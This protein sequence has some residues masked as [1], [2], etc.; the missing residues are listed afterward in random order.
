MILA[1]LQVEKGEIRPAVDTL[2][3]TLPYAA[4]RPII[5]PSSPHCYSAKDATRKR[6]A[7]RDGTAQVA[8][9]RSVVDGLG[10]SLQADNRLPEARNAFAGPRHPIPCLPS[11]WPM[12]NSN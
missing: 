2:R 1:R 8:A 12:S 4:D 9:E 10:I 7:L 6:R 3:R 5:K 11:C